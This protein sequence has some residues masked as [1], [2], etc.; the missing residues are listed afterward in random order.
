MIRQ[1]NIISGKELKTKEGVFVLIADH[2]S[3]DKELLVE[4]FNNREAQSS[5]GFENGF[6]IPHTK[7]KGIGEACVVIVR[8]LDIKWP[9]MDGNNTEVAIA[10]I[11]DE[12]SSNEHLDILSSLSR[13]LIDSKFQEVLKTG[14]EIDIIT[15]LNKK[16]EDVVS[17]AS[18][19]GLIVAV[20]GC[21]TGIAHTF[22]A[23]ENIEKTA[24]EL[25]YEVKV[26]TRGQGGV[27]NELTPD[28]IKRAL[29]VIIA[30][31]V[32]VPKARFNDKKLIDVK[33]KEGV[34]H[35]EKLI[36]DLD[37][38]SVYHTDE[39]AVDNE[40]TSAYTALMSG[41][42][43]MLPFTVAGGI[44]IALSFMFGTQDNIDA[45]LTPII[46]WLAAGDFMSYVGGVLFSM[47]LPILAGY[48]AY[49][50]G[51]RAAL[52]PGVLAGLL[53]SSNGSGFLGAILG[54]FL[55]GYLAKYLFENM[56]KLPNS[57]RGSFQI[58]FMPIILALSIGLFMLFFSYPIG[59]LNTTMTT[60]LES[61]ENFSPILL[62]ALVGGMMAVDMG[63]PINKAAYVTGTILLSEGNQTFMAAVMAGGMVPPLAIALSTLIHKNKYTIDERESAKSNWIMGLSFITEGAI[64]FAAADP[65]R[66]I[67][68]L[69]AGSAVAGSLSML[70]KVTLP[71]PHGGIFVFPLI[72]NVFMYIIAIVA[73]MIVGALM[74]G[75]LKENK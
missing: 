65:K 57:L 45:G 74:L 71:A 30:A 24:K 13:K 61:L 42:T 55:A 20:T 67:P 12:E 52:M 18:N 21:T 17:S 48:I 51:N 23:A 36:N 39:V 15:A 73:G 32:K 68:S 59:W 37:K 40:K 49:A 43:H 7:I 28:D 31:D 47:M 6:A 11:V 34:H 9:S 70:F 26:E 56:H 8:D 29:G 16:E 50:I 46:Q 14:S 2:L 69:V 38:A 41:V 27:E 66:V 25:G 22:M 53:A 72:D 58:L 63:G 62:G 1:E 64:P 33:V 10:I 4:G 35:P 3:L 60:S 54:G 75:L 19:K 44:F 5:T